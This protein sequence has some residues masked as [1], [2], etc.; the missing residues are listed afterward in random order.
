MRHFFPYGLPLDDGTT[1]ATFPFLEG[2][3][4]MPDWIATDPTAAEEWR[5]VCTELAARRA[6]S[7]AWGGILAVTAATYA[8]LVRLRHAGEH[9]EEMKELFGCVLSSYR[10]ACAECQ[11]SPH[12]STVLRRVPSDGVTHG[13]TP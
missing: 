7:P 2:S 9:G 4:D 12:P 5:R 8:S 1:T 3:P 10:A 13:G 11:V 6:L